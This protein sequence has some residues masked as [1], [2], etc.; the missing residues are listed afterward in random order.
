M[1]G[2]DREM[3]QKV[4]DEGQQDD[5]ADAQRLR[6]FASPRALKAL[7]VA[8][9]SYTVEQKGDF[10][11]LARLGFAC[12]GKCSP[13]APL[14]PRW[15]ASPD[16]ATK[17]CWAYPMAGMAELS[18]NSRL[19]FLKLEQ[20]GAAVNA[21]RQLARLLPDDPLALRLAAQAERLDENL[22]EAAELL[23]KAVK[24][25]PDDIQTRK[26]LI[27]TLFLQGDLEGT[28]EELAKLPESFSGADLIDFARGR[29]ALSLGDAEAA[30]R[31][32][33]R[34]HQRQPNSASMLF[35]SSALLQAGKGD[36]ALEMLESWAKANPEDGVI[37]NQL[38]SLRAVRGE[39]EAAAAIYGKLLELYPDDVIS[40]NNLAW[41][42]REQDPDRALA[43]VDKALEKAPGNPAILDTKAMA[44]MYAGEFDAALATLDEVAGSAGEVPP[45]TFHRAQVLAAAGRKEEARALLEK[46][47]AGQPFAEQKKAQ[48]LLETL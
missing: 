25:A 39:D 2:T 28:S 20:P 14:P 33:R 45:V 1:Y 36:E 3:Q 40:M 27:E 30:E 6:P 34:A 5:A 15:P 44:L 24:L 31:L 8:K 26:L 17:M 37:L 22:P 35:L 13:V 41:S 9:A 32:L 43:L 21:G 7:D 47:V 16:A 12:S 42:L 10:R 4:H 48:A 29:L 23:R 19:A 18:Y 11:D 38:G 46:L